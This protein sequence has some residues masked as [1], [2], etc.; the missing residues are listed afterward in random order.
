MPGR[1]GGENVHAMVESIVGCKWSLQILA[2]IREGTRRPGAIERS[3]RGLSAKVMN[4]RLSKLSR[5]GILHREVFAEVPPHVEYR[6]TAFGERFVDILDAISRLEEEQ[7][8]RS[9][10]P[11]D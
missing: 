6:F 11:A 3:I 7:G 9:A 5:F 1:S 10:K 8:P 2:Q 4:E